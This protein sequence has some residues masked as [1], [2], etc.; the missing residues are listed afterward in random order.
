MKSKEITVRC[1]HAYMQI[2]IKNSEGVVKGH[3]AGNI[4]NVI[5]KCNSKTENKPTGL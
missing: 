2:T 1:L 5:K 3:V 4:I